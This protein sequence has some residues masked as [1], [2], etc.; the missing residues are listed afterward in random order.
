M[1]ILKQQEV[2]VWLHQEFQENQELVKNYQEC[3]NRESCWNVLNILPDTI[4]LWFQSYGYDDV[5]GIETTGSK[6]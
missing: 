4:L 6:K 1:I 3:R 5:F 2:M